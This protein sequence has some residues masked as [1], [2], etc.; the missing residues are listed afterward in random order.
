MYGGVNQK[1]IGPTGSDAFH[2]LLTAMSR[3]VIH[4]P[5]KALGGFVWFVTHDLRDEAVGGNNSVFVLTVSEELGTMDVP[6][7]QIAPSAL[8][9]IF[10]LYPH[11]S[12]GGRWQSG[13][14]TGSR[15]N[16]GFLI[17][18]DDEF[19][20][21]EGFPLPE[22]GIE[23]EDAPG[24]ESEIRI[25]GKNPTPVLPRTKGIGT[26]PTP[27]CRAAD[28]GDYPLGHHLLADIGQGE[29]RER[30]PE[31]MRKLTGESFSLHH[32]AGGKRGR[33]GRPEAAP[34]G[35]VDALVQIVCATCS[36]SGAECPN[37]QR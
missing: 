21:M 26:Q 22:P 10:V 29:P 24:F 31:A 6:S 33:D 25:A 12:A 15:W 28:L 3:A 27:E 18:G 16:A 1:G 32:D 34:R 20:T 30:Q 4:D 8:A 7:R 23:I 17:R 37:V 11:R 2:C 9:E 35:L 14:F 19:R 13:L 36:R 5:K